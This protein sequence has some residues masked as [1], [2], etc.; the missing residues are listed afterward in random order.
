MSYLQRKI[1]V[2]AK[3][4]GTAI[5][6]RVS[7]TKSNKFMSAQAIDDEKRVTM[8]SAKGLKSEGTKIGGELSK[9][10]IDMK[11]KT[12]VFDRNGYLYHGRVKALAEA[13]RAGGLIF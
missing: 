12:I 13:L 4:F 10:L 11:V 5:R 6:P 3:I 2:R 9:K 1:R 8:A 7:V